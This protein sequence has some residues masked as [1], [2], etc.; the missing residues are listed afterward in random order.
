[1]NIRKILLVDDEP[2]NRYVLAKLLEQKGYTPV[3]AAN[4]RE[5]LDIL[6]ADESLSVMILDLNMPELDGYAVLAQLYTDALL[7]TRNIRVLIASAGMCD[8]FYRNC[9]QRGIDTTIVSGYL[10]KPF[11]IDLFYEELNKLQELN[12][13]ASTE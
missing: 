12:A 10:E 7:T 9:R 3:E 13:T 5:A 11:D 8:H 1:M 6:S 4:G 2:V